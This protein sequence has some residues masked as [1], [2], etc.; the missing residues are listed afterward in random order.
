MIPTPH[1]PIFPNRRWP[2]VILLTAL[3]AFAAPALAAGTV[4]DG[5]PHWTAILPPLF[6]IAL[7][8][9]IREVI[10]S[11]LIGVFVG[12]LLVFP[13][14]PLTAFARIP[15]EFLWTALADR[16]H[17]AIVLFSLMLG[18]MVGI[19]AKSGGTAGLVHTLRRLTSGRRGGLLMSWLLGIIIFF[20]DYANT[21]LVGQTM[22]P[23]TDR[24]RISRAKLAYIVDST[25]APVTSIAIISTWVGFEVGLIRDAANHLP[26]L[27]DAYL[28]FIRALPYRFYSLFALLFVGILSFTGRDFGPM[29]R[30]EEKAI[31]GNDT[32]KQPGVVEESAAVPPAGRHSYLLALVP[33]VLVILAT[34]AGL[35]L[36][37]VHRAPPGAKLF[38]ILGASDSLAV[39]LV[40]SFLGLLTAGTLAAVLTR[41]RVAEVSDGLLDGMR[42]M[43]PAMVILLLAWA[44][45]D[46]CDRLG[47]AKV[48]VE[49]TTG[50]LPPAL[51][52]GVLF[53][54]A[55]AVAFSTGTSWGTM[56]ILIPIALPLSVQL[57]LAAGAGQAVTHG[58]LLGSVGA[59]LAGSTFGDHCSPISDTTIL[60]SMASGC[61]H[62]AHVRTQ[63]PYAVLA[64][65]VALLVG[66]IPVGF[67]VSPWPLLPAGLLLLYLFQRFLGRTVEEPDP[68][69]E[70]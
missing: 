36:S 16:S 39:L 29:R 58:V 9:I 33:I 57:P 53:T 34:F 70:K 37:G 4:A 31:R 38:E 12:S 11:L 64:A 19:L 20:D 21:L 7:A 26:A 28:L 35:Y 44:L 42:S 43:L 6:A 56:A 41:L 67:G 3:A 59:V 68:G 51:L 27:G 60:S 22:R 66:Y 69:A 49:A 45:G 17:A 63:I 47:T 52:P 15:E 40:A 10:L 2:W 61:D 14:S 8:L 65:G 32:T 50:R 5:G 30:A 18:G 46:V 24:L 55:A 23:Y 62:L 13:A 1:S 25:A 54:V 48:V